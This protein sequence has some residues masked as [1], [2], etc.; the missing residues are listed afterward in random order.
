MMLENET[1]FRNPIDS[2]QG[3][4][5]EFSTYISRFF[6]NRHLNELFQKIR[7]LSLLFFTNISW[8]TIAMK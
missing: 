6:G 5:C 2:N 8:I 1:L 7:M 3:Y 4:D